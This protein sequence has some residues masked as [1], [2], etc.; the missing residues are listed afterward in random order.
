[1]KKRVCVLPGD[2]LPVS[3]INAYV[4]GEHERA[5]HE[6]AREVMAS[7]R[8]EIH[9]FDLGGTLDELKTRC[10]AETG[11]PAPVTPVWA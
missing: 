5:I 4:G 7:E 6:I 2:A 3:L 1:M 8:G 10:L 11:L 9:L